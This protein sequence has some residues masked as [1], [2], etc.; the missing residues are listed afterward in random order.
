MAIVAHKKHR[1][2]LILTKHFPIKMLRTCLRSVARG[3]K[4]GEE[5]R[6]NRSLRVV[7]EDFEQHMSLDHGLAV[8]S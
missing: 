1:E 8:G 3:R 6:R 7:N 2:I 5:Q 4:L